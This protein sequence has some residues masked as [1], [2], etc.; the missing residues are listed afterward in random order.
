MRIAFDGHTPWVAPTA[1]TAPTATLIGRVR[2]GEQSS[3][4]YGAV[5]R[6]DC[7]S[8]TVGEQSNVQDGCVLH[9][10]PGFPLVLGSRVSVGH[11]ATLHGCT[12]GD[13]VLIGMGATVLNGARIGNGVLI[14]AGALVSQDADIPAGVLVAGV[15][16][17]VRRELTPAEREDITANAVSYV[18]LAAAH[19]R[20]ATAPATPPS[21]AVSASGYWGADQAYASSAHS[22]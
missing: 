2:M 18:D 10:D 15:P 9:A 21:A 11:N 17:K 3:L 19:Q 8:I 22:E 12:I 7:E 1:W 6:A 20:H 13:D 14:A 4:W 16:G 5:I